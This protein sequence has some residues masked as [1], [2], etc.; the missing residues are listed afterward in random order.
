MIASYMAEF[1]DLND[2]WFV[3]SPHNPLKEKQSLLA[4]HHRFT[5]VQIAVEDDLRF[6][7]C[8]IEFKMPRPSYTID[9]LTWL[10]EKYPDRKFVV[11]AGSDMLGSLTKWKNYEALLE[12]YQIYLYPRPGS[13]PTP[14][15]HH[16]SIRFTNAPLVDISSSFIRRAIG[17]GRNMRHYLPE[18]VW[19]YLD[20]MNFYK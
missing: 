6:K 13:K 11:V 1:T 8:D 20:E 10:H 5:M 19:R 12:L 9:T 16:P 7:A 3:V 2:V 14:F 17:E 18:K 4:D 15:D